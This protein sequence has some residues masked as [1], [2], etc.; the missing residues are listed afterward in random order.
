LN[1]VKTMSKTSKE[2]DGLELKEWKEI[3]SEAEREIIGAKKTIAIAHVLLGTAQIM[4]KKLKG[5]TNDELNA[6]ARAFE[7]DQ[8]DNTI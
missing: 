3:E 6:E 1:E 7:E 2:I 8:A 4:V 5:K